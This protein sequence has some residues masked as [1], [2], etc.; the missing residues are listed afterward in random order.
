MKKNRSNKNKH[1]VKLPKIGQ[2]P[3]KVHLWICEFLD[4]LFKKIYNKK[5]PD[6]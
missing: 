4:Q 2:Y 5:N 3:K 1:L 6:H